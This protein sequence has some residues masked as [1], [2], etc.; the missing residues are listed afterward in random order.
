MSSVRRAL[1]L[2]VSERYVLMALA[3]ISNVLIAR[4]LT[5]EE[6]GLYSV[7]VAVI[8]LA[9]V[10]RD[11][12]IGSFLIQQKDLH[13]GHVRTAFG[14]SLVIGGSLFL[15]GLL[16]APL[17]AAFYNDAR[18]ATTLRISALNFLVLPFCTIS[19]S[20]LRR[21]MQFGRIAAVTLS[22]SLV[23]FAATIG[24][25]A[26]GFGPNGL[27]VGSVVTN[28]ATGIAAWL[29]R[30]PAPLLMPSFSEWRV[31]LGFGGQS[32]L[33]NSAASL[34]M[35][36]NDLALGRLLGF[37]PVAMLSRAHGL[38]NLFHRD[39]MGAVRGVAYPAYAKA[40]REG[41]PLDAGWVA[42]VGAVTAFAW[43]FYGFASLYSLE[44]M[45]LLFGP[46]WDEAAGLVPWLCL[47]GAV[48]ATSNLIFSA[49][50]A[51]GRI[52]LVTR[53]ELIYQPVRVAIVVSV[54]VVYQSLLA[55]AIAYFIVLSLHTPFA[56]WVKS[57]CLPTD[58]PALREQLLA[59]LRVTG[60][61]LAL[62]LMW[63]AYSGFDRQTP[64]PWWH[65]L[66]V[67]AL[68]LPIWVVAVMAARHPIARDD[69]FLKLLSKVRP[70]R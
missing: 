30:R 34:A 24:L 2:S 42:S 28:V 6:I 59:S 61:S 1:A 51:M 23:G 44:M 9:Q 56:F 3:L 12:G 31:V 43:P 26:S 19:L 57:R 70:H 69:L 29:A 33:A 21:D 18:I 7:S 50:M 8:G 32:A 47:A 54:A 65:F 11:F 68:S 15:L 13:R 25:V 66:P 64:M 22:S 46:Q 39:L 55:C 48:A 37:A 27:A 49:L 41:K 45:R 53:A 5:P 35:D 14:V 16:A 40:H 17:A 20:L 36:I 58:W 63:A 67:C 38:M 4:L 62:P 52:D 60:I 10:V